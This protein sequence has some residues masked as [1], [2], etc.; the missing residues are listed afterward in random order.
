[1]RKDFVGVVYLDCLLGWEFDGLV[2]WVG[3]RNRVL[4]E[5]KRFK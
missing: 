3:L 1:M 4:R 2:C 5:M